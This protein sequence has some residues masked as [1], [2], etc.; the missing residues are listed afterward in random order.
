[1]AW[2]A[3]KRPVPL[4][5][6]PD[7]PASDP[8]A[9]LGQTWT[10][11][12]PGTGNTP[13]TIFELALD[14]VGGYRATV[15]IGTRI[16]KISTGAC[17]VTAKA[18]K[19]VHHQ[20]SD[21]LEIVSLTAEEFRFKFQS[22]EFTLRAEPRAAGAVVLD[23]AS[24]L[25]PEDGRDRLRRE[26]PH[27]VYKVELLAG[28]TYVMDLQSADFDAYLRL[29]DKD[30][31]PVAEDDD[32][33]GDRNAR[34]R[35]TPTRTGEYRV[36]ATTFRGG[37]GVYNLHVEKITGPR[38]TN[39]PVLAATESILNIS[40]RLTPADPKDRERT[41][42]YARTYPVALKAGIGYTIDLV[43]EDFDT[44][45]RLEDSSGTQVAFNDDGGGG[46]NARIVYTPAPPRQLPH[47]RHVIQAGDRS[48]HLD[49]V[50]SRRAFRDRWRDPGGT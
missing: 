12:Q 43:S 49:R 33:G 18:V 26:S 44:Y 5:S 16:E 31:T 32:G 3:T 36:I 39:T 40:E 2:C 22:K 35:F 29:E 25:E 21:R 10:L 48:F 6:K 30:G 38:A 7:G 46:L 24:R 37:S 27:K 45:L 14:R 42:S 9:L 11:T 8:A 4:S 1:M 28:T 13:P 20:G 47:H 15:K 50:R 23:A 19:L 34:I 41:N 17:K